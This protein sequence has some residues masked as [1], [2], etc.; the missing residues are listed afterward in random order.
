MHQLTHHAIPWKISPTRKIV[1]GGAKNGKKTKA[2]IATRPGNIVHRYPKI[3][4]AQPANYQ[5][6]TE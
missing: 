1:S 4:D 6:K 3:S 2:E 5:R